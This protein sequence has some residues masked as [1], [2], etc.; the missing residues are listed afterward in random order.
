MLKGKIEVN[1]ADRAVFK[2]A[3]TAVYEKHSDKF[4]ELIKRIQNAE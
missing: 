2:A 1:D 4:G 3:S